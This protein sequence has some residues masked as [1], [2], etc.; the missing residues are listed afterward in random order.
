MAILHVRQEK[1]QLPRS[2]SLIY[3]FNISFTYKN[4]NETFKFLSFRHV[5]IEECRIFKLKI[6]EPILLRP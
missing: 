5:L 3:F 2:F 1:E 6:K 4:K